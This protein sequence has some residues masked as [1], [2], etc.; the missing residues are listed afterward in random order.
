MRICTFEG[1]ERKH[2]QKGYC[3]RHDSQNKRGRLG[4]V[5]E[6]ELRPQGMNRTEIVE[7]WLN[8]A[9]QQPAPYADMVQ[10]CQVLPSNEK[11][12]YVRVGYDG[13]EVRLHR[14]VYEVTRGTLPDHFFVNHHCDVPNCI[15]PNHLY[16]GTAKEN[17][18]DREGRNRHTHQPTTA[19]LNDYQVRFIRRY[20]KPQKVN[21]Q[22]NEGDCPLYASDM[23]MKMF[24]ISSTT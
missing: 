8:R 24:N 18:H 22:E 9:T 1:C 21:T 12:G 15:N 19:K 11:D 16:M 2:Y 17:A 4:L 20:Y 13:G 3:T 5:K 14:F 7:Y 23:L 10:P 6:R